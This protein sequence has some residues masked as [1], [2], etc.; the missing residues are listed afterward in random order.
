MIMSLIRM[1]TDAYTRI[2]IDNKFHK[3]FNVK[4]NKMALMNKIC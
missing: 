3:V 1:K 2:N 4:R